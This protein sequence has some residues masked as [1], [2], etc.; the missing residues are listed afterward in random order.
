LEM[1][2]ALPGG[3]GNGAGAVLIGLDVFYG[4]NYN[5]ARSM[6][7]KIAIKK[8]L[9][10]LIILS[11][12]SPSAL[13]FAWKSVV[14]V[15]LALIARAD[16]ID[17]GQVTIYEVDYETGRFVTDAAGNRKIIGSYPVDPY[18]LTAIRTYPRQFK[19]GALGPDAYPDILTGQ[20]GIH[21]DNSNMGHGVSDDWLNLL[22]TE[23]QQI[24]PER[25]RA[26]VAGFLTHAA[27]D[28]FGHTFINNYSG[29]P[30][31]IGENALKHLVLESY[32][33]KRTPADAQDFYD[34]SIEGAEDFLY[35][36][37][38]I[39]PLIPAA[40]AG[41]IADHPTYFFNYAPPRIFISLNYAVN[42]MHGGI[43][44]EIA[45]CSRERSNRLDEAKNCSVSDPPRSVKLMGEAAALKAEKT[46]L[47]A[48]DAYF[49]EWLRDIEAGQKA[50]PAF[51]HEMSKAALFNPGGFNRDQ[52]SS[53]A[54]DYF[55]RHLLSM[56]GAP[57]VVGDGLADM[58]IVSEYIDKNIP[59]WLK[60]LVHFLRTDFEIYLLEKA[61][62]LAWTMLQ[63]PEVHFDLV[64]NNNLTDNTGERI[65]L[66]D[67]NRNVLKINDA[68][69]ST[70]EKFDWT[71]IPAMCNS[72]TMM[73]LSMLGNE[74]ANALLGDLEEKGY[75][76]NTLDSLLRAKPFRVPLILGYM[77]SLDESEQWCKGDQM[78]FIRDPCV[79]RKLFA[80]QIGQKDPNCP[81][82]CDLPPDGT[83]TTRLH[84]NPL[85]G[86]GGDSLVIKSDGTLWQ[87]GSMFRGEL[88]HGRY[89]DI[90]TP[91]QIKSPIRAI[92]CGVGMWGA[93]ALASDGTVWIWGERAPGQAGIYN[94]PDPYLPT[95]A[96]NL[97]NITMIAAGDIHYLALRSNGTVWAW[98]SNSSGACGLGDFQPPRPWRIPGLNYIKYIG[99]GS[100]HSLALDTSGHVWAW[101]Y[102][103]RGELG[104]GTKIERDRPVQVQGLDN[105]MALDGG[106]Y[107][108]MALKTD[109]TVWTWGR[110]LSFPS[111]SG[112]LLEEL[113]PARVMGLDRII[114]I[115]A[116]RSHGAALRDDGTVWVWGF[117]HFDQL[118]LGKRSDPVLQPIQV[119]GLPKITALADGGD[120]TLALDATGGIWVWGAP[121]AT[122]TKILQR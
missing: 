48:V 21:P 97:S 58:K 106:E 13:L 103:Y 69:F 116:G 79:Y 65:S 95:Q 30:F 18:V 85:S 121:Y 117:N 23:S 54:Q 61:W 4:H 5:S 84:D 41:D 56:L 90:P 96:P 94:N 7:G 67:F 34:I 33:D 10:S 83:V 109:G 2:P 70:Q 74:G 29:G 86:G 17:D 15:Y 75:T 51:G 71:K 39:G 32:I 8:F 114:G 66:R 120:R 63:W 108:S 42:A 113:H 44:G 14:H 93:L 101:G 19:A 92:S 82:S 49:K 104:D 76:S 36:Q 111:A 53:L 77:Q 60:E 16:A 57:D 87:W 68:G 28:L 118:G 80:R 31:E 47:E 22:W 91:E 38:V 27:G 20:T 46:S 112:A 72:V 35:R 55:N 105:V 12:F 73:K 102:N 99:A 3:L 24:G 26:F 59:D 110:S 78:V 50:W 52:I 88:G 9:S 11:L 107:W 100:S 98:G 64:L 25:V 122:P 119:P 40:S 89:Q 81:G 37:L 6:E 45:A 115:G 62:G 43:I 1:L